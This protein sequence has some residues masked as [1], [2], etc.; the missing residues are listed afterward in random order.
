MRPEL[1]CLTAA[2]ESP[3]GARARGGGQCLQPWAIAAGKRQ[4]ARVC[5]E[6]RRRLLLDLTRL[7]LHAGV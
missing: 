2:V 7:Q 5:A 6:G 3:P 4:R 1:G